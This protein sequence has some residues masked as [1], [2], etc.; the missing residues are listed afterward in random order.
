M[1]NCSD[2]MPVDAP[3]SCIVDGATGSDD[4]DGVF[5]GVAGI[6]GGSVCEMGDNSFLVT[7]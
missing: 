2:R 5:G 3:L 1:S 6:S 4:S 7:G